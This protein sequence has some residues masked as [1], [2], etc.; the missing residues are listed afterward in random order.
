MLAK[1]DTYGTRKQS[2]K[3]SMPQGCGSAWTV[4]G[5]WHHVIRVTVTVIVES[6]Q[7]DN[8][9]LGPQQSALF[10]PLC[11]QSASTHRGVD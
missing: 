4:G 11:G 2:C 3:E 6:T 5:E 1:V 8:E 10:G 9:S 7:R